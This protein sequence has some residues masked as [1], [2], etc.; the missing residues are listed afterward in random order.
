MRE[1]SWSH[2]DFSSRRRYSWKASTLNSNQGF[3][4]YLEGTYYRRNFSIIA[5]SG[6]FSR[7]SHKLPCSGTWESKRCRP[8]CDT[9]THFAP[10]TTN[11]T[12]TIFWYA[13]KLPPS[14]LLPVHYAN[15]RLPPAH[16]FLIQVADPIESAVV[17]RDIVPS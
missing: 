14:S 3:R 2:S 12:Y 4:I 11:S 1:W 9:H 16:D 10:P 8:L 13:V 7:L 17:R 6:E 15:I 5:Q